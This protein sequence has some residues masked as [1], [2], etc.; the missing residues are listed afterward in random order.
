[1][2]DFKLIGVM[3]PN[4]ASDTSLTSAFAIPG[5]Y[6]H[7]AVEIPA[8]MCVTA[9]GNI[10]WLGAASS[11]GTFREIVF[12]N[13]PATSTTGNAFVGEA[14]YSSVASGA[15]LVCEAFMFAPYIKGKFTSTC[16]ANTG[17]KV[18]ARKFD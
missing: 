16:T 15:F 18:Y 7:F 9:T 8:L 17:I 13:N 2:A 5:E 4:A 6:S 14:S 12:S 10:R 3:Y 1:M 11:T